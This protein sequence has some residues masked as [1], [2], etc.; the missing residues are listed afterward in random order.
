[1]YGCQQLGNVEV[2]G[3]RFRRKSNLV[4]REKLIGGGRRLSSL[5]PITD[6]VKRAGSR[7]RRNRA[8]S[9]T[10]EERRGTAVLQAAL[11]VFE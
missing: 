5:F 1:V 11:R 3:D 6:L 7:A 8:I 9:V 10:G 2:A 4:R